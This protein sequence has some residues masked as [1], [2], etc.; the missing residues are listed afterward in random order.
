MLTSW[1]RGGYNNSPLFSRLLKQG[2]FLIPFPLISYSILRS[3]W[4]KYVFE[5][6]VSGELPKGSTVPLK[7][8]FGDISY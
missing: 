4:G 8:R 5:I 1:P 3:F 6:F 2:G 7:W